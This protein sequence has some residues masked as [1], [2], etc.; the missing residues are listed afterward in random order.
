MKRA[1]RAAPSWFLWLARMQL[2]ARPSGCGAGFVLRT[3]EEV[4]ALAIV[5]GIG[6]APLQEPH[7]KPALHGKQAVRIRLLLRKQSLQAVLRAR[8]EAFV[9]PLHPQRDGFAFPG[10]GEAI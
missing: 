4:E 8:D 5:L 2:P 7:R 10:V 6:Q 1:A 9:P 3:L